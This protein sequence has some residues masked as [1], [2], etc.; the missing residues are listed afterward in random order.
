MKKIIKF[1]YKNGNIEFE[2]ID[3]LDEKIVKNIIKFLLAQELAII[4]YNMKNKSYEVIFN[5]IE[6]MI[7]PA[8][9]KYLK[10]EINI[11]QHQPEIEYNIEIKG[12]KINFIPIK[13]KTEL[14]DYGIIIEKL[15]EFYKNKYD[16]DIDTKEIIN[17]SEELLKIANPN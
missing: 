6:N 7:M 3:N 14:I 17:I 13:E 8:Y 1:I 11:F 4:K 2:G 16:E 9:E 5:E 15:K 10:N 12:D